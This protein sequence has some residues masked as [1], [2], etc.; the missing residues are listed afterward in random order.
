M[1]DPY[2]I[3]QREI[4][5]SDGILKSFDHPRKPCGEK[6]SGGITD[7]ES[8]FACLIESDAIFAFSPAEV[9]SMARPSIS[10]KKVMITHIFHGKRL[11][12]FG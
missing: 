1:D 2:L 9:A 10:S 4:E 5:K 7:D 6:C 12:D 8:W 11:T 3:G